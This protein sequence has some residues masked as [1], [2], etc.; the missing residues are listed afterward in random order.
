MFG[1]ALLAASCGGIA[2]IDGSGAGGSGAGGSGATG[3]SSSGGVGGQG[4]AFSST[5]SGDVCTGLTQALKDG[6]AAAQACTP[7]ID[8]IQCSGATTVL[9]ECGC[10][11]VA[12][13][14][15]GTEAT[16]AR[17]TYDGWVETGCGPYDCE[18]CPPPPDSAWYCDPANSACTPG[19]E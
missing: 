12:N 6:I 9:D 3:S 4:A 18:S 19:F 5:G 13:D 2:V 14:L 16:L 10:L 11:V 1:L 17:M 8:I 7:G 15:N